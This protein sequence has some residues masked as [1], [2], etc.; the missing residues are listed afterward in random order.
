[1]QIFILGKTKSG[2]TTLAN[3]CQEQGYTVY[4]AG[5]WARTEF[6]LIN[7]CSKDEFSSEF[8]EN[9]TNY[10][11][12]KLKEDSY[13]SLKK[14]E[15][16]LHE[17]KVE[18]KLVVGVRNPDD[19]LNMLRMDKDNKVIFINSEKSYD[20]SLELFEAGLKIIKDYLDWRKL[21]GNSIETIELDEKQVVDTQYVRELLKGK[22]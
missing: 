22:L 10:A 17:N 3:I 21:L 11:L 14:Y 12:G 8:K 13:Y 9:L 19:F 20:G 2:K 1:M 7:I 18:K 15:S 16:F 5:S 4:E 6:D